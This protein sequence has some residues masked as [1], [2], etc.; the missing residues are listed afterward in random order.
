M[1]EDEKLREGETMGIEDLINSD[2]ENEKK[3]SEKTFKTGRNK[4]KK[5]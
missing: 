3:D 2:N 5:G 1:E 4:D